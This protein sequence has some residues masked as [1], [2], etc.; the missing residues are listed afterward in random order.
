[1]SYA[2]KCLDLESSSSQYAYKTD[3]AGGQLDITTN[4]TIELWA[5]FES[6]TG[7][8]QLTSKWNTSGTN[9]AWQFY[10][11]TNTLNFMCAN[12]GGGGD[13]TVGTWSF[14]PTAGEW[15]HIACV[16]DKSTGVAELF[17][18]GVSQGTVSGLNTNIKN[19][20]ADFAIGAYREAGPATGSYFDGKISLVRMW[21]VKRTGAEILANMYTILGATTNLVAEWVLDNSY[22]DNSGNSLTLTGVG[23]PTFATDCPEEEI[24]TLSG[25]A[26]LLAMV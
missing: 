20:T 14:T 19:N 15:Y 8:M 2:T 1:M 3:P 16:F 6:V 18:N 25:G 9:R 12:N 13:I 26:F 11:Y 17:V 24:A 23:S 22:S 7:T 10:Y 5:K 4:K 21:N